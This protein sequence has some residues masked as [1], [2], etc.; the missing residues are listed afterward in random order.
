[1]IIK[2][3]KI[4]QPDQTFVPG[5]II[6]EDDHIKEVYT[7]REA[8]ESTASQQVLDGQGC[9]CIPGM[10]DLH[11]HGCKGAD[12]CDGTREVL[13]T[14]SQFEASIGVTAISPATMTLPV[15]KLE[16]ILENAAD[17][18]DLQEKKQTIWGADLV[19]VNME[20]PFIS[21]VKKGAQDEKNI[22]P[23]DV[24]IYKKFQKAAR[25]LVKFVG[26]AP[27]ESECSDFIKEVKEEVSVSLAHTNA[28]YDTA[29][30]AFDLGADHAVH[31]YNAMPPFHHRN[32]GVIGAVSD[33]PHVMAELICDGIHI[34]PSVVRA[35]FQMMGAERMILISDSM[36]ATGMPD[37]SYT[38]GGLDVNVRGNR[39]TLASDGALAGSATT[40]PDC[41]RI[42]V[43]KM[44]IPLETAIACATIHP[45]KSLK[46][47]DRYGSIEEGKKADLVL[48]DEE[49]RL[50][51]VIKDGQIYPSEF[52]EI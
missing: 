48:W 13:D 8:V 9:Y 49:L 51:K 27:E 43:K 45:A 14:I 1:M 25:G 39:A 6:T 16:Q 4:Y 32:P 17:Y 31:L 19:G 37:G 30:E 29:M 7:E 15:E 22:I 38:L 33:S 21:K 3:I 50:K 47:D 46:I 10:I 41:V 40:L 42:A 34:H 20:G 26:I 2:N 18:R 12:F 23:C 24:S 52:C 44:G 36:R 35:T 5:V 28:D 11:F